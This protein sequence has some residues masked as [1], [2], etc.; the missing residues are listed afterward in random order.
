MSE[1]DLGRSDL[2]NEGLS[3]FKD[4]LGAQRTRITYWRCS[5]QKTAKARRPAWLTQA[6]KQVFKRLPD[7]L[8]VASGKFLYRHI[9]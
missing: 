2:D 1:F 4:R 8:L 5:S 7:A 9:G 3:T 6:G